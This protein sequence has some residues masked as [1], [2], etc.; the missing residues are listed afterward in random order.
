MAD[1]NAVYSGQESAVLCA[2]QSPAGYYPSAVYTYADGLMVLSSS[3]YLFGTNGDPV[4]A[5]QMYKLSHNGEVLFH[6]NGGVTGGATLSAPI[7]D[8]ARVLVLA[9]TDGW[10]RT[11]VVVQCNNEP[12]RWANLSCTVWDSDL[13]H[14]VTKGAEIRLSGRSME[15][16]RGFQGCWATGYEQSFGANSGTLFVTD[17]IG[18]YV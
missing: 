6:D 8:F 3:R 1:K 4:S 16:A 18:F 17:V 11:S 5:E 13:G 12:E 14:M 2:G 15:Y 9:R 10:Q 7:S